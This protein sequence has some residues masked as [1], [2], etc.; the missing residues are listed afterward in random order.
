MPE[1]YMDMSSDS[2]KVFVPGREYSYALLPQD[3]LFYPKVDKET[4]ATNCALGLWNIGT[5][6]SDYNGSELSYSSIYMGKFFIRKFKMAL[7]W[8]Y[9]SSA[10][11]IYT[12]EPSDNSNFVLDL[13][14]LSLMMLGL[15]LF[16]IFMTR[17]R[18]Q[19]YNTEK[20]NFKKLK[21]LQEE[22]PSLTLEMLRL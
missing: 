2:N 11:N 17:L 12:S 6:D 22:D 10:V 20:E 16:V 3:Y 1:I 18:K 13:T 19:R 14:L 4:R 15:L 5:V 21:I 8:D 7:S 9:S